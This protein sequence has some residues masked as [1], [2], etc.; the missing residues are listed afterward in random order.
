MNGFSRGIV[1][2]RVLVSLG[3]MGSAV[4]ADGQ[5]AP[6][7]ATEPIPVNLHLNRATWLPAAGSAAGVWFYADRASGA[8]V[9]FTGHANVPGSWRLTAAL[10]AGVEVRLE[11]GSGVGGTRSLEYRRS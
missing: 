4:R 1:W 10:P 2:L 6:L 3:T 5:V 7:P 9:L 11:L 8:Q